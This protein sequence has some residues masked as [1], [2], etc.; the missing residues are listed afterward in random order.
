MKLLL[1]FAALPLVV[2]H[3]PA[4]SARATTLVE[5][6]TSPGKRLG[7]EVE[8]TLQFR[9]LGES[10]NPYLSRFEPTRWLGLSAWP[11]EV[12]LW[13][14]ASFDA[15]ATRLFVRRGSELET[16]LRAARPFQR[17][18]AT[19]LVREQFLGEPWLELTALTP[20]P[21]IVGEGTLLHVTRARELLFEGAFDLA[22]EQY[23]RARRAPLP[24][25][26]LAAILEEELEVHEAREQ[27]D[28]VGKKPRA[29]GA[30]KKP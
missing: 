13:D 19:A 20:L 4:Q 22:L 21:E 6:R 7:E 14:A 29:K 8:F 26:A 2:P 9:E 15:P 28:A 24:P 16:F 3:A 27:A 25:H 5:L 30:E 18:R 12:F 11:D 17:L 10:W 23:E 1:L